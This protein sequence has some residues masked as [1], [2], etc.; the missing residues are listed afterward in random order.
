MNYLP[1]SG[2]LSAVYTCLMKAFFLL[3]FMFTNA[4]AG[5][6]SDVSGR[7]E[8]RAGEFLTTTKDYPENMGQ[9]FLAASVTGTHD[10]LSL[11]LAPV[12]TMNSQNLSRLGDAQGHFL[13]SE[14]LGELTTETVDVSLGYGIISWGAGDGHNPTNGFRAF[15]LADPI[16]PRE[17][18]QQQVGFKYHPGK[19]QDVIFEILVVPQ[20]QVD[21]FPLGQQTGRVEP[22]DS[23]WGTIFP[24][25]AELG[26]NSTVPLQYRLENEYYNSRTDA[27]AR[28]RLLQ[29]Q[30]WDYSLSVGQFRRKRAV[31]AYR[32]TGDATDPDL[33]LTVV[34]KPYYARSDMVGAD[35]AGT[36]GEFGVRAEIAQYFVKKS[37]RAF[38]YDSFQANV[39]VDRLW[40][41]VFEE[42]S[43]YVNLSWVEIK[44]SKSS[45]F[46]QEAIDLAVSESYGSGRI[47]L[48]SEKWIQG[49]DYLLTVQQNS[50]LNL[51]LKHQWSDALLLGL[52]GSFLEGRKEEGLGLLA[53][54]HRLI[55]S[56]EYL[57]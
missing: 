32:L 37:D 31:L 16:F 43:L 1:L 36:I 11:K 55:G 19:E 27:A 34:I 10:N 5:E 4:V 42:R 45:I 49:I 29:I 8:L 33:P 9:G 35:A 21:K 14:A 41:H 24:T 23:R 3:L 20:G 18:S 40:D 15:D 17:L 30:G 13:S 2:G 44:N 46:F 57:F 28:L 54:N 25:G 47:E 39:G 51:S 22:R 56:L 6:W 12:Y 26:E 38:G 53:G 7:V 52:T 48:R 50:I